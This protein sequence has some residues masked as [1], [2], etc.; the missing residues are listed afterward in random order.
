MQTAFLMDLR[1][2][3]EFA[4]YLKQRGWLVE[5]IGQDYVFIRKIP[6]TPFSIIKIQRPSQIDLEKINSLARKHRAFQI[7]IEPQLNAI[8]QVVPSHVHVALSRC[9][10]HGF[11]RLA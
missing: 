3:K 7:N 11:A 5:K 4:Q 9:D 2:S 10:H 1:Q 6:L 8:W